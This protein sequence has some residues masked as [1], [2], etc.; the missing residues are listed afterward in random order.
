MAANHKK[1]AYLWNLNA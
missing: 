1:T